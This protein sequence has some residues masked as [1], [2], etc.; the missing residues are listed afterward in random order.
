MDGNIRQTINAF[1]RKSELPPTFAPADGPDAFVRPAASVME[2][3][4]AGGNPRPA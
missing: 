2:D 4:A 1:L 3:A